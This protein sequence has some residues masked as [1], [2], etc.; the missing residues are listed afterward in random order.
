MFGDFNV[1]IDQDGKKA[2]LF[3]VWADAN[4][5]APF[6]PETSTSLRSNRVI[7]FAVAAGLSIDIQ[8]YS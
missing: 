6:T 5:L 8:S 2:E 4:F 7:D 1:D 3:L